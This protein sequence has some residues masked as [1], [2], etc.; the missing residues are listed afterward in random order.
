MCQ[1]SVLIFFFFNFLQCAIIYVVSAVLFLLRNTWELAYYATWILP[2][3][4][5]PQYV[6]VVDP[7][8]DA[9]VTFVILVLIFVIGC[10]K[11]KGLWS[12]DQAWMSQNGNAQPAH[13]QQFPEEGP[14][15]D[16]TYPPPV[17]FQQRYGPQLEYGQGYNQRYSHKSHSEV[18]SESTHGPPAPELD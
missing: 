5:V 6:L 9:W 14:Y 3:K 2:K 15:S 13:I 16:G 1:Y 17:P 8:L 10:R 18:I 12:T 7:I 11:R 4:R